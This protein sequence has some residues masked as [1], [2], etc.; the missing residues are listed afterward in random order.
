VEAD[1]LH[2]NA[3]LR[4][5]VLGYTEKI[6]NLTEPIRVRTGEVKDKMAFAQ[7]LGAARKPA[8]PYGDLFHSR[9]HLRYC[10]CFTP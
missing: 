7:R 6:F 8:S 10:E 2:P 9:W 4:L 3:P 1:F 5:E